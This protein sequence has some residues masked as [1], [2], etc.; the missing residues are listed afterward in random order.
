MGMQF[1]LYVT[2]YC[3]PVVYDVCGNYL[4]KMCYEVLRYGFL[5]S[6]IFAYS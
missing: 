3:A 2:H 1:E 4:I 5:L 6:I